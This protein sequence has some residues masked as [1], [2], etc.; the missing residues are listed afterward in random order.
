MSGYDKYTMERHLSVS[1]PRLSVILTAIILVS[2]LI[3]VIIAKVSTVVA[4]A[5]V[6]G[7]IV[8]LVSFLKPELALYLLVFSMLL[9]PQFGQRT[10]AG[11]G[12]TLR[13]DD[14]LLVFI[15]LSWFARTA[16]DKNMGLLAKT[17]LNLPIFLYLVACIVSTAIGMVVGNVKMKPG[18]FFVLKYLEYYV[19][20]FMTVNLVR[21]RS[22]VKYL[23]VA[24][25]ATCFIVDI[26]A[27]VQIPSGQ[28]LS[29]PFEG[30]GGEPNTLG[31]YLVL[32]LALSIALFDTLKAPILKTAL[33]VI[34]GMSAVCLSL[35]LS[36]G[37]YVAMVPCYFT[38]IALARK[39]LVLVLGLIILILV[40]P[41][42][43]PQ[44]VIDRV[45]FTFKQEV[46][47]GQEKI[48]SI[49]I[50]TSTSQ[51]VRSWSRGFEAV[52]QRPFF[53]YG[54]TGWYFI[55]NQ[56]TRVLVETGFIG[57]SAFL[58]L[59]FSILREGWRVFRRTNDLLFKGISMGF[60]AGVIGIMAHGL[61]A[62]SFIIVRIM[63]PFWL[64]AGI[65]M[66]IP[67]IE[68]KN[69]EA[70]PVVRVDNG[71]SSGLFATQQKE[72]RGIAGQRR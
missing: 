35:T 20:Y 48:G 31:G 5:A 6:A 47:T 21:E 38:L 69:A 55:D 25:L 33:L 59:L 51:R 4:V 9:S 53:G 71:G 40:G 17:N 67:A 13:L 49:R 39:K 45:M 29:A 15:G 65:V 26:V 57:L 2:L 28:R 58:F 44:K 64:L 24:L 10:T 62:N 61:G 36:R 34:I 14:I 16:V 22:Q 32:M 23:L 42:V 37:S 68:A 54:V 43:M 52:M 50:D 66:V 27:M 56:I 60:L 30:E 12:M 63:E 46:Q 41:S 11:E 1:N 72:Y 19:V 18:F 8:C 3:S 70:T 7:L